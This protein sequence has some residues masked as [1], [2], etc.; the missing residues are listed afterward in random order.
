M[1]G[2]ILLYFL[3]Q[4]LIGS[5]APTYRLEPD[6]IVTR[7]RGREYRLRWEDCVEYGFVSI[8]SGRSSSVPTVYFSD[9]WLDPKKKKWFMNSYRLKFEHIH[10]LEIY[11]ENF[12]ELLNVLPERL[13][14]Y[15]E[16]SA[17]LIGY[18]N[19]KSNEKTE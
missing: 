12:I 13:R 17:E 10:Y 4:L 15:L 14:S 16:V 9:Q 3:Y 11:E 6:A 2:C 18:W 19:P 8:A 1:W 7:W 5:L